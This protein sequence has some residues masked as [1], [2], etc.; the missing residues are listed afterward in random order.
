ME[1]FFPLFFP[2]F[3]DLLLSVEQQSE[4]SRLAEGQQLYNTRVGMV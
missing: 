3:V 4:E 2:H 1:S